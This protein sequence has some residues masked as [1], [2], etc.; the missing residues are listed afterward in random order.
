VLKM[1]HEICPVCGNGRLANHAGVFETRYT[2]RSGVERSLT[3]SNIQRLRCDSCG[4]EILDDAA[5][6]Q[7]EDARRDAAGLLTTTE[8]RNLR[9]RLGKSQ[10]QMSNLLGVGEKTYCRWESGS[11]LQSQAFDNYLRLVRDV[12]EAGIRLIEIEQHGVRKESYV[13]AEDENEFRFLK[14]LES[15]DKPATKFTE[16]LVTGELHACNV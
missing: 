3:I 10:V 7:I 5:T 15:F 1:E 12:P 16:L 8:I 6:R 2:D 11:F 4:E 13:S 14:N 9:L